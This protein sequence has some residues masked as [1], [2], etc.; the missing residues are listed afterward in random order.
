[1]YHLLRDDLEETRSIVVEYESQIWTSKVVSA[2]S[3]VSFVLFQLSV[4]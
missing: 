2:F 3:E 1:M 4:H